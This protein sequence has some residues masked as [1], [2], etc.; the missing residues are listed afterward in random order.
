[1]FYPS[2]YK[3]IM[4]TKKTFIFNSNLPENLQ[5]ELKKYPI[6][7]QKVWS[8]ISTIPKGEVK[9]YSWVAAKI[10][11][12]KASRAVGTALSKNP[13]L[14][15]IPCHRVIRKDGSLGGF[16]QGLAKKIELLEQEGIKIKNNRV[17]IKNV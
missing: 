7:Y 1:M 17:D 9:T 16:S 10:G 15:I 3:K 5:S 4:N 2:F 6:F 14:I 12:P 13:F 8:A 11:N